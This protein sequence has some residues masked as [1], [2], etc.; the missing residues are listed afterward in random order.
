LDGGIN[1]YA[2]VQ[3]DP[4]NFVD[5]FGREYRHVGFGHDTSGNAYISYHNKRVATMIDGKWYA[6]DGTLIDGNRSSIMS[7]YENKGNFDDMCTNAKEISKDLA[8]QTLGAA[9]EQTAKNIHPVI[10]ITTKIAN[11]IFSARPAY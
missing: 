1:L 8:A 10:G 11:Y 6:N 2:Y 4:I 7:E 3:N 9:A 5:P